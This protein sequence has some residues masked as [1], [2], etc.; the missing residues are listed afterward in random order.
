MNKFDMLLETPD[1]NIKF[2]CLTMATFFHILKMNENFYGRENI[3]ATSYI[4]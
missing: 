2:H 4:F 3:R 1:G